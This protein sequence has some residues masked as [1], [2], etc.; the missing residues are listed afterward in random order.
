MSGDLMLSLSPMTKVASPLTC[1]CTDENAEFLIVGDTS[2]YIIHC[3]VI[4]F[5]L[6]I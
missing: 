6:T 3:G 1:M 5:S 2:T 4:G